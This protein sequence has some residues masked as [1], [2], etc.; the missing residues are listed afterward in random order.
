MVIEWGNTA[1]Q[2]LTTLA[3]RKKQKLNTVVILSGGMDSATC[4]ALGKIVSGKITAVS[5]NYGQQH[6]KEIEFAKQ[7]ADYFK[8]S[9]RVIELGKL[10]QSF[11][12]ALAKGHSDEIPKGATDGVPPTYVPMRNTIMLSIAAGLAESENFDTIFYGAN[13]ID[14]SGYPDC[15]PEYIDSMNSMLEQAIV[16]Q[17]VVIEAPIL[18]LTKKDVVVLGSELGVPWEMTWSCY[19]GGD[20]A[21]GECPSCEYRLKGFKEAGVRDGLEYSK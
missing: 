8:V 17:T 7:L 1:N 2:V 15:R 11:K 6:D 5:F 14:Y 12:T 19:R 21:C 4:L 3:K 13:I 10:A 20:K 18:H 16:N 9:H